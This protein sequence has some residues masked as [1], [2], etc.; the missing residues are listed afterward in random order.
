[1]GVE[2]AVDENCLNFRPQT[3]ADM[4]QESFVKPLSGRSAYC[5]FNMVDV[6][7]FHLSHHSH[8]LKIKHG[9]FLKNLYFFL[10]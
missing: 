2:K 3:E 9:V 6:H 10:T 8:K 1:M 7:L 4:Q 5:R